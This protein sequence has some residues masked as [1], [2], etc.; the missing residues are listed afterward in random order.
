MHCSAHATIRHSS[1]LGNLAAQH[2]GYEPNWGNGG[3]VRAVGLIRSRSRVV[4]C[5]GLQGGGACVDRAGGTAGI[6]RLS[7]E[8][9]CLFSEDRG[10]FET[11]GSF[12]AVGKVGA[13]IGTYAFPILIDMLGVGP[14]FL[15][16]GVL[17]VGLVAVALVFVPPAEQSLS[18]EKDELNTSLLPPR[19][20]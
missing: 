8:T 12:C 1:L 9:K 14:V 17:C 19:T 13:A 15:I 5:V 16:A 18:K 11:V 10:A 4:S 3:G 2:T 20:K 7:M 6:R